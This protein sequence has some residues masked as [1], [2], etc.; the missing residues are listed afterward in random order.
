MDDS[1]PNLLVRGVAFLIV[2]GIVI[3]I[4]IGIRWIVRRTRSR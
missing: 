1:G 4:V 3:A 2:V